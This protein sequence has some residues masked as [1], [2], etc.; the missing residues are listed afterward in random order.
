MWLRLGGSVV[1][2]VAALV[3]AAWPVLAGG[4]AVTTL[5]PLPSSLH[6]NET[7]T[8]GYTIRQHG[9]TPLPGVETRIVVEM[10]STGETVAF[11]GKADGAIG[12]YAAE[13]R[14]PAAGAWRWH[15]EQGPFAPQQLGSITV[16][17]P[18][19][20]VP[21]LA[22]AQL[23]PVTGILLGLTAALVLIAFAW[24]LA[25]T[26]RNASRPPHQRYG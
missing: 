21:D 14:F 2:A 15:V 16:L 5:D 12:H 19:G 25:L 9:I 6:A 7:Y 10:P 26:I 18:A 4:F 8:L 20:G 13:V 3:M 11:A 24:R 1:L 22:N 23:A 17:A